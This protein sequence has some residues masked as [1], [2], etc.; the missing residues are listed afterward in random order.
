[1]RK[2]A[3]IFFFALALSACS[4]EEVAPIALEPENETH[5]DTDAQA[6]G[7]SSLVYDPMSCLFTSGSGNTGNS[8]VRNQLVTALNCRFIEYNPCGYW[9]GGYFNEPITYSTSSFGINLDA[10]GA[11]NF[12]ATL[13]ALAEA[14]RNTSNHFIR[15][16]T[17]DAQQSNST[18]IVI[19]VS[20]QIT[21][22]PN[23]GDPT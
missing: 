14:E 2:V 16:F 20:Y 19:I 10:N 7:R 4:I 15:Q 6:R 11:N 8:T 5:Q 18:Q 3:S 12:V 9:V 21:G 22:C 1:M 13:N 17:Y 23:W